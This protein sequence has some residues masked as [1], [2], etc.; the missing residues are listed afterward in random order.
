M[1]LTVATSQDVRV[2]LYDALGREVRVLLERT[3]AAGQQA[4][5]GFTTRDLPAGV[6]VVRATGSDLSLTQQVTVV[7]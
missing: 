3:M 7:R 6:Y 2:A 4:H 1:S 5:L